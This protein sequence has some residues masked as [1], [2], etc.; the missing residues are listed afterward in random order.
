MT[1]SDLK[2]P[3]DNQDTDSSE[4]GVFQQEESRNDASFPGIDEKKV[5]RK[6]DTR[7]IPVLAILYLLSFLDVSRIPL[8]H[9]NH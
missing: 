4:K 5:L 9:D 8:S 1:A 3:V 7:L 2:S 6:M